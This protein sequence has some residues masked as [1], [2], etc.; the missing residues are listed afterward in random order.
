MI[1][2]TAR[3]PIFPWFRCKGC[4][5]GTKTEHESE[6]HERG[7]RGIATEPDRLENGNALA[8][9]SRLLSELGREVIAAQARKVRL[10]AGRTLVGCP[11]L[12][13]LTRIDP[14]FLP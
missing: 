12:A 14:Q 3:A 8:R 7:V 4:C 5:C 9:V 10:V 13:G 2:R 11:T 6:G 1:R